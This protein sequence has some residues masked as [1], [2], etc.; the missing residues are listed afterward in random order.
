MSLDETTNLVADALG[1][2]AFLNRAIGDIAAVGVSAAQED[3]PPVQL[4]GLETV[5]LT[6]ILGFIKAKLN[7][8][9]DSLLEANNHEP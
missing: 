8:A 2:T 4:D 5:G 9:C 7:L 3:T 6:S 1:M